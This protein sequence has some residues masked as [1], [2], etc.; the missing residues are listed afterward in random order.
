MIRNA[1][2]VT[3]KVP[4]RWMSI[5]ESMSSTV[6]SSKFAKRKLPA[7]LTT[8]ST[9][10]KRETASSTIA[11]PPSS[12]ATQEGGRA[13]VE[14]AVSRFGTVDAVVNNAGNFRFANF[15]DLTVDDID[16]TIDIHLKGTFW[17]TQPAFLIMRD[18]GYGRI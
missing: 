17:V 1:G 7:L 8:A 2:C 3:Q 11:R 6:R 16:S 4:L 9:V 15:E 12:V 14:L 10:P 13:I 18:K 5:V